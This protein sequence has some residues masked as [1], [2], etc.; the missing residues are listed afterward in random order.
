MAIDFEPETVTAPKID[1]EP[2]SSP[3]A[4]KI[5]FEAESSPAAVAPPTDTQDLADA[6][7]NL[8]PAGVDYKNKLADL[9]TFYQQNAPLRE[10]TKKAADLIAARPDPNI[11]PLGE[12]DVPGASF[13]K[14]ADYQTELRKKFLA[15]KALG[16]AF[17]EGGQ[18]PPLLPEEE[19]A[20][21]EQTK[22]AEA[23][24]AADAEAKRQEQLKI[25]GGTPSFIKTGAY[26]L[27][28]MFADMFAE[29]MR[30][31]APS[32]LGYDESN[33]KEI[34]DL[35]HD[36]AVAAS[37]DKS[38]K[39]DIARGAADV[40]ALVAGTPQGKSGIIAAALKSAAAAKSR[41]LDETGDPAK[42]DAAG[43]NSLIT[44]PILL[45]TGTA[46]SKFASGLL[47]KE[48]SALTRGAAELG[49]GATANVGTDLLIH[50]VEGQP[51]DW[52]SFTTDA[53]FALHGA[54]SRFRE[55]AQAKGDTAGAE[56]AQKAA[57]TVQDALEKKG[58]T[59]DEISEKQRNATAPN[60]D[61]LPQ[62]E[63]AATGGNPEGSG[64]NVQEKSPWTLEES[65]NWVQVLA[66]NPE[67]ARDYAAQKRSGQPQ[68]PKV[69]GQSGLLGNN[70]L[71]GAS[72]RA[73]S[74]TGQE[75]G[76]PSIE[77]R[78]R[79][80]QGRERIEQLPEQS[81]VSQ[82][83]KT[84]PNTPL[85][86]PEMVQ[87]IRSVLEMPNSEQAA[88]GA[89]ALH[90]LLSTGTPAEKEAN[91]KK[92][93]E[94]TYAL[95]N[96][97]TARVHGDVLNP[98][99]T[100][101]STGEVPPN[102]SGTGVPPR[103]QGEVV[104]PDAQGQAQ[105]VAPEHGDQPVIPSDSPVSKWTSATEPTRLRPLPGK[106]AGG[107][108][109]FSDIADLA[110]RGIKLGISKVKDLAEFTPFRASLLDW[111]A[112]HQLITQQAKDSFRDITKAVPDAAARDGI[113]NWIQAGGDAVE[114]AKR[115]AAT[116]DPTLK[117]GYEAALNLTPEQ[118]KVATDVKGAY[119]AL[120]KR[121]NSYGINIAELPNYVNQ[122]WQ[123]SPMSGLFRGR[124]LKATTQHQKARFY[125]NY[126][127]GEQAGLKPATK[128]IGKLLPMYINDVNRAIAD[129]QLVQKLATAKASDGR[130]LLAPRGNLG[131]V[132]THT[133]KAY[134]VKPETQNEDINDY[135]NLEQP[136]LHAWRWQ[137]KDEAGNPIFV[138]SDLVVHPEIA[139]HLKNVLNQPKATF[140][141]NPV[142]ATLDAVN[143]VQSYLK[144]TMLGFFSPFHAVTE[145]IHAVGHKINPI[146]NLEKVDLN[147][148]AH[149]DAAQHGLMLG[150]DRV[151]ANDFMEGLSGGGKN[152][153]ANAI[154]KVPYLKGIKTANDA[155]Q[156]WLFETYIP[157]LKLKTYNAALERNNAR[158]ATDVAAGKVSPDQIKHLTAE[159][160]NAAYG[161]LNYTDMGRN[162][163]LQKFMRLTLLAPD[164]LEARG[165]FAA[166]AGKALLGSKAG[167]E[168]LGA[169]GFI[170]AALFLSARVTNQLVDKDPHWDDPFGIHIGNRR[171]TVRSVPGDIVELFKDQRKFVSGR[172]SPLVGKGTLEALSGVNY[173]GE[174]VGGLEVLKD[175]AAGSVP[176]TLQPF[177]RGMSDTTKNNPVSIWEQL[178]G[179]L[180]VHVNR[181]SP[182]ND[183]YKLGSDWKEAQGIPKDKGTYPVSKYQQLRYALED[184]DLERAK[185]EV[186]K[187]KAAVKDKSKVASGFKESLNH[188][189]TDTEANDQ[190]MRRSLSPEDRQKFDA[191][192]KRRREIWGRFQR[193]R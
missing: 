81:G 56:T 192:V 31:F 155:I 158:Y 68:Y 137:G 87:A 39:G 185:A 140:A 191:A 98:E 117:K 171:Y 105:Q 156:N 110:K 104:A 27:Q 82:P 24:A 77:E 43:I 188:P 130:P 47:P 75:L 22:V 161:H 91:Q 112:Q 48:A 157:S 189:F 154:G 163:T 72:V 119:D 118:V 109:L 187:L 142:G 169:L 61:I 69:Q 65:A 19:K 66:R 1:F 186:S 102:E 46:A 88:H 55:A 70:D 162:P 89:R 2:E 23:K 7:N 106:E 28:S 182:I 41:T 42:A 166:Q 83:P 11:R 97:Q 51:Y 50:A 103:G 150:P 183:A 45:A 125:D 96:S 152:L 74:N 60:Q 20:L 15:V 107:T 146:A 145:G 17:I 164:F 126:F 124:A 144:Q 29:T 127:A 58:L 86:G 121:A 10:A 16:P 159:Q 32:N 179:A 36:S 190:K 53:L 6:G 18:E 147:N 90:D 37:L 38:V 134:F 92:I 176:L 180:G 128:D 167:R 63:N 34:T 113:T 8:S 151:S 78:T 85:S 177:T 132:D 67:T 184:N 12:P 143:T 40:L 76:S 139:Q 115:A 178:A 136:A 135:R 3:T 153:I 101:Q 4:P 170:G 174:K 84:Q 79:S 9:Q 175:V 148:P 14:F 52:R 193:L 64:N 129:K 80:S 5:D 93:K 94:I 160:V 33:I 100:S 35:A 59:K 99:G 111:S 21:A 120:L 149:L 71:G 138:K 25:Y 165:R 172:L 123:R 13:S 49:A 131:T 95:S 122:L 141:D 168:Q 133:G 181:I 116:T 57:D 173:R 30:T 114:L 44:L 54:W 73:S 26:H 62:R 108:T